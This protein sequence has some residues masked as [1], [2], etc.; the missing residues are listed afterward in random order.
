[1]GESKNPNFHPD[2]GKDTTF[3]AR[4]D[5]INRKGRPPSIKRKLK[6]LL[7]SDGNIEI[8]AKNVVLVKDNGNVV[9][10]V[11]TE[12]QM[13]MKLQTWAMSN[14]G[15]NS[16]KALQ[17]IM[18]QFDG[19]GVQPI[20]PVLPDEEWQDLSQEE[21]DERFSDAVAKLKNLDDKG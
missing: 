3:K 14:N 1:M 9:I 20:A 21:L 8:K 17:M 19:K 16:L 11:P 12:M 6:E 10:R 13:A 5:F 15:S 4:P 7:N 18:E 2:I